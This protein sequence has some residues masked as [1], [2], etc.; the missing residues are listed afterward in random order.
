MGCSILKQFVNFRVNGSCIFLWRLIELKP[1]QYFLGILVLSL[2]SACGGGGGNSSFASNNS[3]TTVPPADGIFR[4]ALPNSKYG[5]QLDKC[6]NLPE[7]GT[8]CTLAAMSF[9]GQTTQAPTKDDILA[10]TLVSHAWMATRFGQLLDSMPNDIRLLF[11]GVTGVVIG[12]DIRPSHYSY[13]TGAIYLDPDRLWLT[14]AERNTVS[15]VPDFR[16]DFGSELKYVSLWRYLIAGNYAWRSTNGERSI[17]DITI[18]M[19]ALLFHELAHA[20]DFMPPAQIPLVNP[21]NT[22]RQ[23]LESL[24]EKRVSYDLYSRIP[25][26]SEILYGLGQVLFQGVK[27]TELQRSYS[28]SEVG[29][30]FEVDGASDDY[31]YSTAY[32]DTAMLFEEVMM[33]YHYNADREVAF[34][35]APLNE[36]NYCNDYI[37]RWG[38]RNRIGDPLVKSRA[39]IVVSQLLG[40]SDTSAYFAILPS[41]KYMVSG[42]DWCTVGAMNGNFQKP[43]LEEMNSGDLLPPHSRPH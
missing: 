41:P 6:L 4:P 20:N 23:E 15:T 13:N 38:Q 8:P 25:L 26:Q 7:E 30:E 12:A 14:D 32:E 22:V 43:H 3:N 40:R 27:A 1:Y 37:V 29:Q 11:R 36:G 5:N 19:A 21:Q 24:Y 31:A 35:D 2:V 42:T 28:A 33:K 17:S 16:S 39:Q 9:I 18:P 34:T 10:R